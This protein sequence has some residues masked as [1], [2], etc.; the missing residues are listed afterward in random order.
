MKKY[1]KPVTKSIEIKD[2]LLQMINNSVGDDSWHAKRN[3]LIIDDEDDD[4]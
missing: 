4:L 3:S 1:N 2:E